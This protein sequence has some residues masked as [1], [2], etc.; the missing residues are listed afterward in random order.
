[1]FA[2]LASDIFQ[3]FLHRA[4]INA[5]TNTVAARRSILQ[6]R[7][8]DNGTQAGLNPALMYRGDVAVETLV[9]AIHKSPAWKEGHNAIILVWDENDYSTAPKPTRCR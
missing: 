6:L 7:S 1:L 8:N 2:D 5:T 9:N 3:L 4:R